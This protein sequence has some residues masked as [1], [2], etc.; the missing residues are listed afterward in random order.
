MTSCAAAYE[1][2][3]NPDFEISVGLEIDAKESSPDAVTQSLGVFPSLVTRKGEPDAP[4]G[5]HPSALGGH[6][7]H[8]HNLWRL[9]SGLPAANTALSEQIDA[10]LSRLEG[11]EEQVQKWAEGAHVYVNAF[12]YQTVP[13]LTLSPEQMR[14]MAALGVTLEVDLHDLTRAEH[15]DN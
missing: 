2:T 15:N 10:L 4:A 14:R 3:A 6:P 7:R 11:K 5:E 8:R 12:A 9:D 1:M 13:N